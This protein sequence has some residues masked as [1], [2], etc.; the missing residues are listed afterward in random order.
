MAPQ[1][2]GD[3]NCD[4]ANQTRATPGALG[5]FQGGV[6]FARGINHILAA[7]ADGTVLACGANDQGQLGDGTT[8]ASNAAVRVV[9]LTGVVAVAAGESYSLALKSDGTVW[10]WGYNGDGRL[11]DGTGN[12]HSTPVQVSGLTGVA[13][14][15]AGRDFGLAVKSDGTV[16]GWGSNNSGQIGAGLAVTRYTPVQ[17][18]GIATATAVAAGSAHSLARLADGTVRAWG[19]NTKGQLGDGTTNGSTAPVTVLGL[20]GV[21][22]I[23]AR[24]NGSLARPT[25][26]NEQYTYDADG[27]R[28]T[29]SAGGVTWLSLGGGLWEER[30][31][32]SAAGPGGWVVRQLYTLQG[33]AVAQ[34]E[35]NPNAI[36][37]PAGRVYLHGD[38]LGSVS[39]VTDN[40]RRVLSRQD[41]TPW[42]E[43]R[44]GDITQTTL[45]FTGQRKDGTGLLYYGARYY[46]PMLGRFLSADSIV[47]SMADGKGGVAATLGQDTGAA[48]RPLTTDFHEPGFAAGL[49]QE[50]AFTQAKGFRFQLT[51]Q[52]RQQ[53]EGSKWQW[54]PANPQALNRYS[55]VLDNPLRYTDPT[56][57][58]IPLAVAALF[59]EEVILEVA[60]LFVVYSFVSAVITCSQDPGCSSVLGRFADQ[61]NQGVITVQQFLGSIQQN[62]AST[63]SINQVQ[64][65][66]E[67]GQAPA[68]IERADRDLPDQNGDRDASLD[69]IHVNG[70]SIYRNGKVRHPLDSPLTKKQKQFLQE[71]GF[72]IPEE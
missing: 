70:G 47:P 14:I 7:L 69:E 4:V 32:A 37:Y 59:T 63:P 23:A 58:F 15:A 61:L 42:G 67:R 49:A 5:G 19:D 33:R 51:D 27:R 44:G 11:G 12:Q 45:D 17:M 46:D 34:Q 8:N 1:S 72:A 68:G 24:A 43:A 36:N 26:A 2:W 64:K 21:D 65:K 28:V 50:D 10:S 20:Q 40:D 35:S 62:L 13:A 25:Q 30:L 31:G 6:A 29:R 52:D 66:I 41:Y 38:H 57:H 60:A 39:V 3:G 55:Y 9:G 18:A 56:G 54:G 53:G 71:S 16:W 48:L 22:K